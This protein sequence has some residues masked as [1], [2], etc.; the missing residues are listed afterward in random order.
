MSASGSQS[1]PSHRLYKPEAYASERT[2]EY[3]V[4]KVEKT[5]INRQNSF[6]PITPPFHHSTIPIGAKPLT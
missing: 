5:I 2:M 6:K 3:W 4:I 1:F